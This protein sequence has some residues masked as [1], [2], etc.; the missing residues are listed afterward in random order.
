MELE[1]VAVVSEDLEQIDSVDLSSRVLV[2]ASLEG[3][4]L[5]DNCAMRDGRIF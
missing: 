5:I 4:R 2:A 3:V 1:Y